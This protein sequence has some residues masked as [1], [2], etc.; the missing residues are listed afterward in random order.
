[1]TCKQHRSSFYNPTSS[2]QQLAATFL[3]S[4]PRS[5]FQL[6]FISASETA[7]WVARATV[8][9]VVQWHLRLLLLPWSCIDVI[10]SV[11]EQRRHVRPLARLQFQAL[12]FLDYISLRSL[13]RPT[14]LW[15]VSL[16]L[17]SSARNR[18]SFSVSMCSPTFPSHEFT[19]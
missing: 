14:F 17:W 5:F 9:I 18:K 19:E 6:F 11:A 10:V 4:H 15:F 1:M 7:A 8:I 16:F 3:P 12:C 13:S 2:Q